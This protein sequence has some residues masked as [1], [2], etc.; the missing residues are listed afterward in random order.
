MTFD[1]FRQNLA[2]GRRALEQCLRK[3]GINAREYLT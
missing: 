3:F 1:A 2:R